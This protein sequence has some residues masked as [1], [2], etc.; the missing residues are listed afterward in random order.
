M[1]AQQRA[2]IAQAAINDLQAPTA[3]GPVVCS[4][5]NHASDAGALCVA[6]PHDWQHMLCVLINL[7]LCPTGNGGSMLPLLSQG[8]Q[9][10][11]TAV[12]N[13]DSQRITESDATC[14]YIC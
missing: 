9:A 1:D 3:G 8:L 12:L 6:A 2:A 11:Y 10:R 7:P 5:L 13:T 4:L 14:S